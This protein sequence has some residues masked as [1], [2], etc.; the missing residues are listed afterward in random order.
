MNSPDSPTTPL[1]TYIASERDINT[2]VLHGSSNHNTQHS[3]RN[4]K[5]R[6]VHAHGLVPYDRTL[7]IPDTSIQVNIEHMMLENPECKST[8]MDFQLICIVSW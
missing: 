8:V 2:P 6:L 4:V 7:K 5:T 1:F 3:R